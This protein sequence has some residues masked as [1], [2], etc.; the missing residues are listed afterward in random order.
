MS[1]KFVF[2]MTQNRFIFNL[3]KVI[4][5]L[6]SGVCL[7]TTKSCVCKLVKNIVSINNMFKRWSIHF[8]VI[9]LNKIETSKFAE[10]A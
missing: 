9:E 7:L 1:S 2:L 3:F 6:H 10:K 8:L 5:V 4:I